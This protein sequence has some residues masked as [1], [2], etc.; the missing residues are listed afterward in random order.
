[1]G[2]VSMTGRRRSSIASLTLSEYYYFLDYHPPNLF[3][4][5]QICHPL[6]LLPRRL[7]LIPTATI[8][9]IAVTGVSTPSRLQRR[10]AALQTVQSAP[11]ANTLR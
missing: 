6:A 8:I 1:M 4:G 7:R 10:P 5:S 11:T 9:V 3:P 2:L